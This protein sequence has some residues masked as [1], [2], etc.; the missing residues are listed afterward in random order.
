MQRVEIF[1]TE[2]VKQDFLALIEEEAMLT[3]YSIIPGSH[4]VGNKGKRLGD[5]VWPERNFTFVCYV[6][7][8]QLEKVINVAKKVKLLFPNEGI[9][10]FTA[11]ASQYELGTY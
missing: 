10:L 1:S 2:A 9:S 3:N 11:A 8:E 7:D 4:G 5:S 6:G